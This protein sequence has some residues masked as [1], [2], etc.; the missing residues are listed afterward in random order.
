MPRL[1]ILIPADDG[2]EP[3]ERTL[4]SVLQNRPDA[5]E[6]IVVT[7]GEYDDPYNLAGE[8]RF[9][10][11]PPG[12]RADRAHSSTGCGTAARRWCMC[13]RAGVEATDRWTDAALAHFDDAGIA[14]VAPLVV[15]ANDPQRVVS[16]GLDYRA[17]GRPIVC[18]AGETVD[19][20]AG[21]AHAI[22]GPTLS[23]AFYRLDALER[24]TA[25]FATGLDAELAD[26]DWALALRQGGYRSLC[27]PG[28]RVLGEADRADRTVPLRGP[29]GSR[30]GYSGGTRARWV[31]PVR[32][33]RMRT[34]VLAE[35]LGHWRSPQVA[36]SRLAGM[37]VGCAGAIA[38]RKPASRKPSTR[39]GRTEAADRG[40]SAV[41]ATH[42]P[43][44]CWRLDDARAASRDARARWAED[45]QQSLSG[46]QPVAVFRVPPLVPKQCLH[47]EFGSTA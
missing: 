24:C 21:G 8:V 17:G 44:R 43:N 32:S 13:L 5:C 45:R 27:E 31:G 38:G 15:N 47:D 35:C 9:L 23:A 14:A 22:V 16:A 28:S 46:C 26:V 33:P 25:G 37:L 11:A 4:V 42:A 29:R 20:L 30:S 10:A 3:L 41:A 1:S 40:Q 19:R 18:A 39:Q 12:R 6:V 2:P 7:R 34:V 36:V